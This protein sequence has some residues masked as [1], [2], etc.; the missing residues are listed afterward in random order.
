MSASNEDPRKRRAH[1]DQIDPLAK[2]LDLIEQVHVDVDALE[3]G[4]HQGLG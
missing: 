1:H 4:E 3:L 2:G